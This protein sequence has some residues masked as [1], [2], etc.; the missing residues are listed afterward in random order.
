MFDLWSHIT[1]EI[2]YL[3]L[4][5]W[6]SSLEVDFLVYPFREGTDE[7]EAAVIDQEVREEK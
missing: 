7:K 5:I 2:Y 3:V 1:F 6:F 4:E